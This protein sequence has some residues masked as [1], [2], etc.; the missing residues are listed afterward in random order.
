[1]QWIHPQMQEKMVLQQT[2]NFFL[3]SLY[4]KNVMF[5]KE[6]EKDNKK[7]TFFGNFPFQN[8][9]TMLF[10]TVAAASISGLKKTNIFPVEKSMVEKRVNS[11]FVSTLVVLLHKT[12]IKYKIKNQNSSS[13]F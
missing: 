10:L 4:F 8:L 3:I 13:P 5:F 1:M 7:K 11:V 2:A 12:K 9:R 6:K